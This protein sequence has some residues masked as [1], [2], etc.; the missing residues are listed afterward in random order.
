MAKSK[1]VCR[2]VR[3]RKSSG[4]PRKKTTVCI[5]KKTIVQAAVTGLGLAGAFG[6]GIALSKRPTGGRTNGHSNGH[7][8]GR[9]SGDV[10]SK[11]LRNLERMGK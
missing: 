3:T 1:T 4:K 10:I 6:A 7:S 5:K 11:Y 2:T 8:N 9:A